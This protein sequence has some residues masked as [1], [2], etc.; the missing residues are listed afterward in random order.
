MADRIGHALELPYMTN[1]ASTTRWRTDKF[2]MQRVLGNAGARSLQML[3]TDDLEAKMAKAAFEFP[4]IVKPTSSCASNGLFLCNDI[5]EVRKA[6]EHNLMSEDPFDRPIQAVVVQEY[7]QGAEFVVNTMS[8]NGHHRV[9]DMW[10]AEKYVRGNAIFYGHQILVEDSKQHED[11]VSFSLQV[12]NACGFNGGAAHLEVIRT[13]DGVRLIEINPR[14]AGHLPRAT[15]QVGE[16]QLSGLAASLE[17]PSRFI[18]KA[19]RSPHYQY[20]VANSGTVAVV[21]LR[22][23]HH[24]EVS[25]QNILEITRLQT[26][27]HF[28]RLREALFAEAVE[29]APDGSFWIASR[30][31]GLFTAPLTVILV[32]DRSSIQADMARIRHLETSMYMPFGTHDPHWYQGQLTGGDQALWSEAVRPRVGYLVQAL[33]HSSFQDGST[34]YYVGGD[35]GTVS[36]H[37]EERLCITWHRTGRTS[38]IGK[39]T[40]QRLFR[41]QQEGAEVPQV[42]QYV[43]ALPGKPYSVPAENGGSTLAFEANDIGEVVVEDGKRLGI[44]WLK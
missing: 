40:W 27:H 24:S 8:L 42:G 32:G 6:V 41:I 3:S 29:E 35:I 4:V 13:R 36:D 5:D 10:R 17:D 22:A 26:F 33:P 1:S 18:E 20:N 12:L 31:E 19:K 43:A 2:E 16:D 25:R 37:D 11:V 39:L 14:P 34:D 23:P 38:T 9:L 30:T 44:R 28:D 15:F 7:L 21:F